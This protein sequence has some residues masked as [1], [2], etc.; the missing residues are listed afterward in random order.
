MNQTAR[1]LTM[2]MVR[3]VM[4]AHEDM[5]LGDADDRDHFVEALRSEVA[6]KQCAVCDD[7][8]KAGVQSENYSWMFKEHRERMEKAREQRERALRR[9]K[10]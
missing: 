7:A 10:R 4:A 5:C 3:K 6:G 8:S 9:S 1:R 2:G